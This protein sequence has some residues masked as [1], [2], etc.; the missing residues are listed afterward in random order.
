MQYKGAKKP[1]P[2][3]ARELGVR[4]V[5]EGSVMREGNIVR[6]SV[7][8]IDAPTDKHMWAE[9]YQREMHGVLTLTAEVARA[10]AS[11]VKVRLTPKEQARLTRAQPVNP[12]A[13]LQ[14]LR[15]R[16]S[17]D[18]FTQEELIHA[19]EHF[20]KATGID[21]TYAPAYAGMADA[22]YGFSNLYLSPKEAMPRVKAAAL[23]A[24][25]L[26]E[27]LAEAHVS[28][29]LARLF[30][31]YDYPGA[32]AELRQAIELDPN[33]A[34]AHL[35]YGFLLAVLERFEE[36]KVEVSR[37]RELDPLSLL[38]RT[39]G[40]L[41]VYFGRQ[42]VQA[43]KELQ[44]IA[45]TDPNYYLVYAYLGMVCEQQ[46]KLAEAVTD[47]ERAAA[48]DN[49]LEPRAQL[50][51]AYALAGRKVE[52][53]KL[54][55]ELVDRAKHQYLSPYN[56]ALIYVGLGDYPHALQSLEDAYED[57]SEWCP[58]LKVDPR[59]DPLR[60]APR[61]QQLLRRMNFLP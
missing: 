1:L 33:Y 34:R 61:F 20:Q 36:A 19:L 40:F 21:P 58:Y 23:K 31:D 6:I 3:I 4:G 45:L 38:V 32:E 16:H 35:Q 12:E 18:K 10:I 7:E 2:Q 50:A 53:R 24:L 57:R 22:Y 17:L 52:A 60:S 26:D 46:G 28:L 47:F 44:E 27:T 14:Y 56:I 43:A 11:E 51:H 54:L 25:A 42:Y 37:A 59:L 41:P 30:Y 13:H 5:V 9:D 8:L 55:A 39:Y 15:G 48:L 29:S 49:S